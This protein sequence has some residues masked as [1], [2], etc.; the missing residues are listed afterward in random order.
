LNK[1]LLHEGVWQKLQ[2]YAKDYPAL[3]TTFKRENIDPTN[4]WPD[5][6]ATGQ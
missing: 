6:K 5:F 3:M 4:I 2:E 1:K